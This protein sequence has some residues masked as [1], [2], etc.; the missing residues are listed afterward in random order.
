M[1][2]GKQEMSNMHV[3]LFNRGVYKPVSAW[4]AED[5]CNYL[6]AGLS[7]LKG[8]GTRECPRL[9]LSFPDSSS[10]YLYPD[11]HFSVHRTH[12]DGKVTGTV[13][14]QCGKALNFILVLVTR[15]LAF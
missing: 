11:H 7:Y 12:S 2:L 15:K 13:Q 8:W 1:A 6:L 10:P 14:R 3:S 5:G 9:L 4:K